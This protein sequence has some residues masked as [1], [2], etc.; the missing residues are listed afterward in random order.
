MK[1]LEAPVLEKTY[2]VEEYFELEKY[3]EIRHE[4]YYGKLIPMPGESKNANRIAGNCEYKFRQQLEDKGLDFF[5]SDIR[6][7]VKEGGIYRYPDFVITPVVDDS[8]THHIKQPV[9]TLEVPSDESERR[10]RVTKRDEYLGM[11]TLQCYLIIS[12]YEPHVDVYLRD[13]KGWRIYS[14]KKMEDEIFFSFLGAK[15]RVA[16]IYKGIV[17]EQA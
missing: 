16:D 1:I 6:L 5:H 2:T 8:H 4:Y 10:D 15:L 14:F 13:E 9:L 12:Q 11:P 7:Q 17:F 3:A